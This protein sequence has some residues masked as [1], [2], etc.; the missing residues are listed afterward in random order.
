MS[1]YLLPSQQFNMEPLC[2]ERSQWMSITSS[3]CPVQC[4]SLT[5]EK[6]WVSFI[7]LFCKL[8]VVVIVGENQFFLPQPAL[9]N[10]FIKSN[11]GDV[12]EYINGKQQNSRVKV[13]CMKE[14]STCFPFLCSLLY[15][16]FN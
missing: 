5:L 12:D 8:L 2:V 3:R 6:T 4:K 1:S 9:V 14:S 10:T 16:S 15:F 13:S 11:E 7:N